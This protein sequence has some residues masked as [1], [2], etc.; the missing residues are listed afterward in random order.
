MKRIEKMIPRFYPLDHPWNKDNYRYHLVE[1]DPHSP[2]KQKFEETEFWA[3]KPLPGHLYRLFLE[4]KVSLALADR[5]PQLKL[6]DDRL[7]VTGEKGYSMVRSTH[8]VSN[9]QWYFEVTIK[10]K[11]SNSALRIGWAQQLANLQATCG[12]DKFSYAW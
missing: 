6:S 9:G 1:P 5:A 4:Q 3:G 8:G 7:T 12:F 2:M 11:P 10:E